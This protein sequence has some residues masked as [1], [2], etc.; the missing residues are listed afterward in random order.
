MGDL[1]KHLS[2]NIVF[3]CVVKVQPSAEL[4]I[5]TIAGSYHIEPQSD[6]IIATIDEGKSLM[7]EFE[8]QDDLIL[9]ACF[10]QTTIIYTAL[11]GERR[12]RILNM[13]LPASD[14]YDNIY[15]DCDPEAMATFFLK[16]A[17]RINQDQGAYRM[18]EELNA[19]CVQMF[20]AYRTMVHD[21]DPSPSAFFLPHS[22]K[23][24][25]VY[26]NSIQKLEAVSGGSEMTVDDKAYLIELIRGMRVEDAMPFIY[27]RVIQI[28]QLQL[29]KGEQLTELPSRVRANY[30]FMNNREAYFIDNGVFLF[31]WIGGDCFQSW[32]QDVFGVD[33]YAYDIKSVGNVLGYTLQN[34]EL[35]GRL[36]LNNNEHSHAVR[37]A[38]ELLPHGI[39]ER[40]LIVVCQ[41]STLEPWMNS[42]MAEENS[43]DDNM[44]YA[45][46]LH[47]L[48]RNIVDKIKEKK[49]LVSEN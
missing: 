49:V 37:R 27:P 36:P 23:L 47:T 18:S 14:N 32:V 46:Y 7:V 35:Q 13:C 40:K 17:I 22:L 34:L 12:I 38:I 10:I 1:E 20:T 21:D 43:G 3:D 44:S 29:E 31:I 4:Q 24:L 8:Y 33:V 5:K 11:S 19:R 15:A 16:R 2:K 45:E 48:H 9:P 25:P 39:R 6:L 28:S 26:V 42:Y 41:K 30:K